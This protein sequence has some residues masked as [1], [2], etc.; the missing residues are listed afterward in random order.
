LR[1]VQ[2]EDLCTA[3]PGAE[4]RVRVEAD[5]EVRLV[6]VRH[7]CALI[8]R[9]GLIALAREQHADAEPS[10]ERP[11]QAA[12]DRQ[13][14]VLLERAFLSARPVFIAAVPRIDDDGPESAGRREIEKWRRLGRSWR[15]SGGGAGG[16]GRGWV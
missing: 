14:H 7:R 15:G 9:Q 4:G 2:V 12:R 1:E 16:G 6:V 3:D 11:L 8:Q 13:R 10:L 5:E